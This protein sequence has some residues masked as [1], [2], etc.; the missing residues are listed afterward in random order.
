MVPYIRPAW[1]L[2]R[3]A[4]VLLDLRVSQPTLEGDGVRGSQVV[5]GDRAAQGPTVVVTCLTGRL[6]TTS[7]LC[8]A[9]VESRQWPARIVR[10]G[11]GRRNSCLCGIS[12]QLVRVRI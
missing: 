12:G 4:R 6:A 8:V 10:E 1:P 3:A 7:L 2:L 9:E 11:A 5:G